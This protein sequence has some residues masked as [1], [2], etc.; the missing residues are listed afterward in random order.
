MKESILNLPLIWCALKMVVADKLI[1]GGER[2]WLE[3][4][5]T[6]HWQNWGLTQLGLTLGPPLPQS[7]G[8]AETNFHIYKLFICFFWGFSLNFSKVGFYYWP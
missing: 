6:L 4:I 3:V 1:P 7:D 5:Y 8:C 2:V